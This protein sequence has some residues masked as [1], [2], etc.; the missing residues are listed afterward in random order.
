MPRGLVAEASP[1]MVP[2]GLSR[3]LNRGSFGEDWV[4][5]NLVIVFTIDFYAVREASTKSDSCSFGRGPPWGSRAR[6]RGPASQSASELSGLA[7]L[8]A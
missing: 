8:G 5:S 7:H 4:S 1:A 6:R 2:Q 3:A